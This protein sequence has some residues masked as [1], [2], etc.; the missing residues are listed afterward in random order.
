MLQAALTGILIAALI[1]GV[2]KFI[3]WDSTHR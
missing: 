3:I 2:V 1:V